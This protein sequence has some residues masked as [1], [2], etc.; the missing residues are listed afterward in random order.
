MVIG[1][2]GD[3][4]LPV[5][6]RRTFDINFN[7]KTFLSHEATEIWESL[8]HEA[9]LTGIHKNLISPQIPE[10]A[11]RPTSPFF[12]DLSILGAAG[13]L[14]RAPSGHAVIRPRRPLLAP[15]LCV[16][17]SC[18]NADARGGVRRAR[19]TR[20]ARGLPGSERPA[21]WAATAPP[22]LRMSCH[23]A[24]RFSKGKQRTCDPAA[25]SFRGDRDLGSA[26]RSCPPQRRLLLTGSWRTCP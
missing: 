17:S 20:G 16:A 2:V 9:N 5:V 3:Q 7:V 24:S 1:S 14:K 8:K 26:A 15:L 25:R 23:G 13:E 22:T 19:Q 11:V 18:G 10:I 12:Q 4:P 21:F 6:D